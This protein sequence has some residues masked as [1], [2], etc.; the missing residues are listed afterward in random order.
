MKRILTR[1]FAA[2]GLV[3]VLSAAGLHQFD[4]T[5]STQLRSVI[6]DPVGTGSL[7]FESLTATGTNVARTLRARFSDKLNVRDFAVCD[8]A[9]DDTTAL[10]AWLAAVASTGKEG[11]VPAGTCNFTSALTAVLGNQLKITFGGEQAVLRYVGASTTP[12]NLI[13]FGDGSTQKNGL[14]LVGGGRIDSSTTLA[15]G[16]ALYIRKTRDVEIDLVFGEEATYKLAD[17][18]WLSGSSVT[19]LHHSRFY[20]SGTA[21]TANTGVELSLNNA[22]I[23]G[24]LSA[25]HGTGTAVLIAGGFGGVNLQ[26]LSQLQNAKGLVVNRSID[27]DGNSQIFGGTSRW[28]TNKDACWEIDDTVAGAIGKSIDFQSA[29]CASSSATA[30][31]GHGVK[32]TNW[33]GGTFNAGAG[34]IK[35]NTG[36]GLK[37]DD[38]SVRVFLGKGLNISYN[39]VYGVN[40][41]APITIYT[42]AA[43]NNNTTASYHS[44]VTRCNVSG[45]CGARD[46]YEEGTWT[47]TIRG[48]GTAGTNVY[49]TQVGRYTRKGNEVTLT[50]SVLMS[51]N[52]VAMVG[53]I[54]IAGLPFTAA[55][56]GGEG[57][58]GSIGY[59]R[60]L[61]HTADYKQYGLYIADTTA[62]ITVYEFGKDAATPTP[63][64][65]AGSAADGG[66][67][68]FTITYR[69]AP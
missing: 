56:M 23:R 38:A 66:F 13:T 34:T 24:Q 10:N 57:W 40:A 27:T 2:L 53:N 49:A 42:D 61:T 28:D 46:F 33:N 69:A 1:V 48:S 50:G 26:N 43:P 59:A 17:G 29:W 41:S 44:N 68:S 39:Q 63:F 19:N 20:V 11:T 5:T 64:P 37:F 6:T 15:S 55:T 18:L 60:N 58:A 3:A 4:P 8:G 12:G 36:D 51:S 14:A 52:S 16:K 65:V 47:P 22:F 32:I 9:T 25:G 21:V 35:N 45:Y 7:V 30:N 31:A 62:V 67:G 54:Q